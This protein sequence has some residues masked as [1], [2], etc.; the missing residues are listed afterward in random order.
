MVRCIP[1]WLCVAALT[2]GVA[3]QISHADEQTVPGQNNSALKVAAN[4]GLSGPISLEPTRQWV[5]S[6]V[7]EDGYLFNTALD[8]SGH[9]NSTVQ[10][11]IWSNDGV[12]LG[13]KRVVPPY[14]NTRWDALKIFIAYSRLSRVA[15][16]FGYTVY[17]IPLDRPDTYIARTDIA[18]SNLSLPNII[19]VPQAYKNDAPVGDPK[20]PGFVARVSLAIAGYENAA[21]DLVGVVRRLSYGDQSGSYGNPLHIPIRNVVLRP[22]GDNWLFEPFNIEIPYSA[23]VGFSPAEVVT[24]TPALDINGTLYEGNVHF[25]FLAGGSLERVEQLTSDD[26]EKKREVLQDLQRRAKLLQ[27]Q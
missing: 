19:W 7:E 25:R 12:F 18:Q 15:T 21:M 16:P 8:V 13:E 4:T 23:L 1:M 14:D 24:L 3:Q 26:I 22:G 11:A 2:L 9:R 6:R 17:A 10:I 20:E 27:G 5:E